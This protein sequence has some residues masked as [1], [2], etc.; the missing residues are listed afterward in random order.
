MSLTKAASCGGRDLTDGLLSLGLL[1]GKLEKNIADGH[2]K[3]FY[4]HKTGH[5]LG[6]ACTD[7]GNIASTA[8][9][10]CWSGHGVHHRT[11]T[12]YRAGD[13]SVHAKWRGIG[14]R[15]EDDVLITKNGHQVLT[16]RL[17]RSADEIEG[18]MKS[19]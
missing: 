19:R 9:R 3:R 13:T 12:L 5:W 11:R 16:A 18:L 6:L 7:V 2:Y 15:T 4:R 17:A 1:K 8:N 10:V 14:I